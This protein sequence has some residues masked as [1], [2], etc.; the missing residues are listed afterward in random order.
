[1]VPIPWQ[2]FGNPALRHIC[3][4]SEH[5]GQP[6]LWINVIELGRHDQR[7]HCRCSVGAAFG[8]GEQPRLATECKSSKSTLGC[9]VREADPA[10]FD[11]AGKSVPTLEHVVDRLGDRGRAR[12][13][14]AAPLIVARTDL[15]AV[16]AER[17]ARLYAAEHD[18]MLFEPPINLPEFTISV[19]TN[20]ARA[21]DPALQW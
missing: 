2:Q 9:I 14:S 6:C 16:I 17:I 8:A 4:A 10:V 15:V 19:L 21:S 7:G 13:I 12:H 11:E 5:V 3:D 18:L 20:A 1:M